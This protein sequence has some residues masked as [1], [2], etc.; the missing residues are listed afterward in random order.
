[1]N[2]EL[3]MREPQDVC[4]GALL[5]LLLRLLIFAFNSYDILIYYICIHCIKTIY[6]YHRISLICYINHCNIY[7]IHI[8]IYERISCIS[9]EQPCQVH[10]AAGLR[11][12]GARA[13]AVAEAAEAAADGAGRRGDP[14]GARRGPAAHRHVG[15]AQAVRDG[16]DRP[17]NVRGIK[18]KH[19]GNMV[20]NG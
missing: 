9:H 3:P 4:L 10:A 20:G 2:L 19:Q 1:M 7:N 18:G 16:A 11:G 15:L 14:G 8:Y 12:R 13:V 6:H 17:E 5:L